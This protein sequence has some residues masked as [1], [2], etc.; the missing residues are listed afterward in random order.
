[1]RIVSFW[2]TSLALVLVNSAM[3]FSLVSQSEAT[4]RM[5]PSSSP[6]KFS[7]V[8]PLISLSSQVNSSVDV[9]D[10]TSYSYTLLPSWAMKSFSMPGTS[11]L[12]LLLG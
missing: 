7:T 1:M 3:L 6:Q 11:A 12:L 5:R 2:G 4:A 8:L 10:F 9:W